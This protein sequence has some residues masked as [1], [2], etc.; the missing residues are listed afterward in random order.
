MSAVRPYCVVCEGKSEV[1]Y[2][3]R[4]AKFLGEEAAA[5]GLF[6]S[7]VGFVGKPAVHGAGGGDCKKVMSA[8]KQERPKNPRTSFCIWVDADLYVRE[9][10]DDPDAVCEH[11]SVILG[12][13]G[14]NPPFSFSALAFEDFLAMHFDDALYGEWKSAFMATGHFIRPLH[15][16]DYLP[17]FQPFWHRGT[18]SGKD[19]EKGD[20]PDD[21]VSA[22]SLRNLFRHCDDPDVLAPVKHL[23]PQ[24][25]FGEFLRT[26]IL[27]VFP[28]LAPAP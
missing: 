5:Q 19:Y 16:V 6:A 20:L 27:S 12:R 18:G 17:H 9:R 13:P 25:T 22:A 1:S 23:T 3:A 10:D 8:Y 7:P 4:L 28:D 2:L 24:P 14:K 11:R 21:W 15:E 26:E